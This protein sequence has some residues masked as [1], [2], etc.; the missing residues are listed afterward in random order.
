MNSVAAPRPG[1]RGTRLPS[2][3]S[4]SSDDPAVVEG[5][6]GELRSAVDVAEREDVR[7]A[8]TEV[9][10]HLD[11]ATG[12]RTDAGLLEIEAVGHRRAA[13]RGE[14][15]VGLRGCAAGPFFS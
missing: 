7:L 11:R 8:G 3:R 15:G 1:P 9:L 4:W 13:G 6:V 5:D 14:H 2:P 10:V 12:R